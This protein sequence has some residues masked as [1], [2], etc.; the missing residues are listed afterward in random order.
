M[1]PLISREHRDRVASY[2]EFAESH[3]ATVTVDGRNDNACARPGFFLGASLIDNVKPGTPYYD[4]EISV[5][6]SRLCE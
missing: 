5:L 3:G 2:L 1:G 4:D 6:S